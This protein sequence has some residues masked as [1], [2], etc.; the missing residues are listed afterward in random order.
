[1]TPATSA[2]MTPAAP[3]GIRSQVPNSAQ[4]LATA[5]A[6]LAAT[7]KS[8][9]PSGSTPPAGVDNQQFE[10]THLK[11]IKCDICEQKNTDILYKCQNCSYHHQICSRC[12]ENTE[13]KPA[14]ESKGRRDWSVH[15]KLK[16]AH[17]DYTQPISL[18]RKED[19][20]YEGDGVKFVL[21]QGKRG[22]VR[23]PRTSSAK[24]EVTPSDRNAAVLR[25]IGGNKTTEQGR[26]IMEMARARLARSQSLELRDRVA[27]ARAR[28]DGQDEAG[29]KIQPPAVEKKRKVAALDED[30]GVETGE[31]GVE[32]KNE[33]A[34][35]DADWDGDGGDEN[36][37]AMRDEG[38]DPVETATAMEESMHDT[39]RE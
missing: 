13:P 31:Y 29:G 4:L 26:R 18:G 37:D 24:R 15:A 7:K 33:V 8:K 12:V 25:A 3:S 39:G 23:K 30:G 2:P 17:A 21:A 32:N 36:G 22:G 1:M 38:W 16:D 9:T 10:V 6:K 34:L 11:T 5:R 27:A 35:E 14:D 20:G 28:R 19:G